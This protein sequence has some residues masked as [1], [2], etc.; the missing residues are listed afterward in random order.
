[1]DLTATTI[2]GETVKRRMGELKGNHNAMI[3]LKFLFP[4][5]VIISSLNLFKEVLVFETNKS[6]FEPRV[7]Y[8]LSIWV[9]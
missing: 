6:E 8:P 4:K 2:G 5:W 9:F 1:M 7:W 3:V